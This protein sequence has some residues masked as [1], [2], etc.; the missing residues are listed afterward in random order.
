MSDYLTHDEVLALEFIVSLETRAKDP[1][2]PYGNVNYADPGHQDDD[3]KRY[4]LDTE[5]HVRAAWSYI[6]QEKNAAKY[7]PEQFASIKS[8]I[9]AAAKRLGIDISEDK[10]TETRSL[11]ELLIPV[12]VETRSSNVTV[13][14][15]NFPKGIIT[16]VAA[17]Y[18]QP[19]RVPFAGGVWSEIFMR[20]AFENFDPKKRR[21]PALASLVFPNPEHNDGHL[22]GRIIE[23]RSEDSGLIADVKIS[24]TPQGTETL[25]LANDGNLSAS[26]GF[27]VKDPRRDQELDRYTR[28]RKI[29]RAFLHHLAFVA[30]PAYEGAEV[31]AVRSEPG[32]PYTPTPNIDQLMSDPIWEWAKSR[33]T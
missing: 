1:K 32:L 4:P 5:E 30:V 2:K 33:L 24:R 31:L 11:D 12:G 22:V 3:K 9:K 28:T 21:V 8:K 25:E 18:N 23:T 6:N 13:E 26:A 15:V 16:V 17:P 14:D 10:K 27:Q 20:S 29:H 7:S 19:T